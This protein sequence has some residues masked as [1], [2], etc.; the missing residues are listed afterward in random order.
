MENLDVSIKRGQ[1]HLQMEDGLKDPVVHCTGPLNQSVEGSLLRLEATS[2]QILDVNVIMPST[3]RHLNLH[4]E[5]GTARITDI[6]IDTADINVGNG[7][8]LSGNIS[9]QWDMNIGRGELTIEGGKGSFD[10]NAGMGSVHLQSV[11]NS[12]AD[13]NAGMGSVRLEHS[14]G[15]FDINAGKGDVTVDNFGGKIKVNA[16]LGKIILTKGRNVDCELESGM[17]SITLYEGLFRRAQLLTGN[18]QI[19]VH[20]RVEALTAKASMRGDINIEIP[21]DLSCRIEAS[22]DLGR[23]ISHLDLVEVNNP[24]PTR[25]HRLV[26]QIGTK[27]H[28]VI[29][30]KTR[31]GNISLAQYPA[32]PT[33][34]DP[35]PSS[36]Q[37]DDPRSLILEKLQKGIITVDEASVLLD[38]LE[39]DTH[40]RQP[41]QH[42]EPG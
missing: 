37:E 38:R 4:L 12:T 34:I 31:K 14:Q 21:D 6:S 24:G 11:D 8:V 20:A 2:R 10:L 42:S 35:V 17:G 9:G 30:L 29:Y 3:V 41:K 5:S 27:T 39:S 22:T 7:A 32:L 40:G 15:T 19:E 13:I 16:G 36:T 18:G 33:L 26:G 28:G 25:G 23:I 1:I